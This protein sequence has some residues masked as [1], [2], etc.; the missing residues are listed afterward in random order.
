MAV[1]N[2]EVIVVDEPTKIIDAPIQDIDKDNIEDLKV[3]IAID[4]SM[5]KDPEVK[6][7]L[8]DYNKSVSDKNK[9]DKQKPVIAPVNKDKPV[10]KEN[11]EEPTEEEVEEEIVDEPIE[12]DV[13][14]LLK[15]PVKSKIEIKEVGDIVNILDKN[16]GIKATDAADGLAKLQKGWNSTREQAKKATSLQQ[17]VDEITAGLDELPLPILA[18]INAYTSNPK[19]DKYLQAFNANVSIVDYRKPFEDHTPKEILTQFFPKSIEG[20]T[21]AEIEDFKNDAVLNRVYNTAEQLFN[22]TKKDLDGQRETSAEQDKARLADFNSSL[23]S[24]AETFNTTYPNA[25]RK[26]VKEL[27]ALA[28][29][30]G[31]VMALLY[32]KKGN[33]K[34]DALKSLFM[35]K[36]GEQQ[37]KAAVI[38]EGKAAEN[39]GRSAATKEIVSRGADKLRVE[40]GSAVLPEDEEIN[41]LFASVKDD[42]PY[43]NTNKQGVRSRRAG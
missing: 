20:L 34:P 22:R 9:V 14:G 5:A 24:S 35:L 11:V 18:A 33:L 30:T 28:K 17:Q 3:L 16:F 21:D 27:Q 2:E 19:S 15:T 31:S 10:V 41:K 32:D 37:L 13:L 39:R 12:G 40:N 38:K 4:P 36:Y 6:K 25:D 1:K 42:D 29:D 7:T 43:A 8:A 26:V 23:A